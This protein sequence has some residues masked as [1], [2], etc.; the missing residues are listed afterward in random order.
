MANKPNI[1]LT[2][3]DQTVLI[4]LFKSKVISLNQI[5][6]NFYQ[7]T[8]RCS[9]SRRMQKL[10]LNGLVTKKVLLLNDL[11]QNVYGISKNGVEIVQE[12]LEGDVTSRNYKSDSIEHDL[13]LFEITKRIKEFKAIKNVI[14]ES[15]LQ[16]C[17]DFIRDDDLRSFVQLRSDRVLEIVGKN[18][19][20]FAALE[21]ERSLKRKSQNLKKLQDYYIH[22]RVPVVFY[23]CKNTM[24]MNSL[25][26]S[27]KEASQNSKSKM[28]F[29]TLEEFSSG[30]DE[31]NFKRFDGT[32]LKFTK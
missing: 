23:I 31:I 14:T 15:E 30:S 21:Y 5:H 17:S 32:S 10:F 29:I 6:Q 27:D 26:E 16:S 7:G 4:S 2:K 3:R 12:H 24:I 19:T 1:I 25:M 28:Y 20:S 8:K 11:R 22:K 9:P 13:K 18:K